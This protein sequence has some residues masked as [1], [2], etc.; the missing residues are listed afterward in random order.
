MDLC[1]PDTSASIQAVGKSATKSERG[2]DKS[3]P[4][5]KFEIP[6]VANRTGKLQVSSAPAEEASAPSQAACQIKVVLPPAKAA[7]APSSASGALTAE[8]AS[9]PPTGANATRKKRRNKAS[10]PDYLDFGSG[11]AVPVYQLPPLASPPALLQDQ[12]SNAREIGGSGRLPEQPAA[13]PPLASTKSQKS[14]SLKLR[15][16]PV[17]N[18]KVSRP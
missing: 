2:P 12:P 14:G 7:A 8:G 3:A 15:P 4:A 11:D 6:D 18:A 9:D 10:V 5:D 1:L 13:F 16:V 17:V